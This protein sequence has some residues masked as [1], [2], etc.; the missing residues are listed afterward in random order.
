[1]CNSGDDIT[2]NAT[3]VSKDSDSKI[4]DVC[5]NSGKIITICECDINTVRPKINVDGVDHRKGS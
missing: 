2:I 3:V 5:L 4:Y 1:M